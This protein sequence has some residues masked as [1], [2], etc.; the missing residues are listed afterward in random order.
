MTLFHARLDMDSG[1]VRYV[2]A[3]HGV[4]L[5]PGDTRVSVSD[6]VLDLFD[7]TLAALGEV[8]LIVRALAQAVVDCLLALAATSAPD[9]VTA[10]VIRRTAA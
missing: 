6:G 10:V 2:D 1:I 7:G 9:D 8:D 5:A 3:G 4:V